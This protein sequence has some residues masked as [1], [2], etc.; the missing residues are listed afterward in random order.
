M[1]SII[2]ARNVY[3]YLV[4]GE[5]NGNGEVTTGVSILSLSHFMYRK[6]Y[7]A[8]KKVTTYNPLCPIYLGQTIGRYNIFKVL[9]DTV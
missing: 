8:S 2:H 6:S 1:N 9:W 5:Q 7:W 4:R 3:G